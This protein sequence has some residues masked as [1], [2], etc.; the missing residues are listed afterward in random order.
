MNDEKTDYYTLISGASAGI[1]K[2]IAIEC[3][4]NGFNLFLVSLPDKELNN[5]VNE[6][7]RDYQVDVKWLGID[8]TKRDSPQK[9][10]DFARENKITV[11]N[12]VNNA[13]V[14]FEGE[15]EK[16]T[17]EVVDQMILLNVRASTML[18]LFFL[19]EMK[20]LE[21]AHILNVSS[22]ASFVSLPNKSV[23][24][25][26]KTYILFFTRALNRELKNSGVLVTSIHP[27][28]VSS[29]RSK[30]GIRRMSFLTRVTTLTPDQVARAA[31]KNMLNDKK[32]VVPGIATKF[33]YFLGYILPQGI[34]LRIVGRI[35]SKTG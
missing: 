19:P 35:F 5:I 23:Y 14:G 25:A 2:A 30:A 9:V 15:F 12:L 13:G 29:E 10:F 31:V 20:K 21:R 26:S 27:S 34:L 18:T 28:G 16:L 33:Y 7:E 22:F 4:K 3:A 24:A 1:G 17:P 11:C 8:L 32:L 6:I